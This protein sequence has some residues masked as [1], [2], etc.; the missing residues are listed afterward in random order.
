MK[1]IL[2]AL[3]I[4]GAIASPVANAAYYTGMNGVIYSNICQTPHYWQIQY[5]QPVGSSCYAFG[6]YGYFAAE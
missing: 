2:F 5:W 4:V 1:K 6:E 3:A